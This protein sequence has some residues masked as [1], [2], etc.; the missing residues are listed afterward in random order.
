MKNWI[1]LALVMLLATPT[2]YAQKNKQQSRKPTSVERP[3]QFVLLAFDGSK[4]NDFWKESIDFAETVKTNNQAKN[5]LVR[6][7]YF[8]NP[9]YYLH[10]SEKYNYTTPMLNK[11]VSCIGWEADKTKL[12]LRV[13]LTN[14][15]YLKGHEIASHA[16]AHCDQ[17]G[18]DKGDPMFG[19]TW[20][21]NAW[22][23]EFTQFN[24]LL[25]NVFALNKLPQP[26]QYPPSGFAF[27][28]EN[29]V[30]F[31]AP[32]L[33]YTDGLWPTLQKHGFRY[34]TS[35]S[36]APNYWPQ[37]QNWGGWNFPLARIKIAG[38]NRTTLS[39]DFNWLV[40]HSAGASKPGLTEEERL[41][42]KQQMLDS[43]NFYFK[44]NYFGGRA[45]VHI[46]HHF[47]KWNGSAYWDAMKEFSDLVCNR[48]EVRC[49]TY[50]EYA[51]WL[52]G[53]DQP[54][55][56]AYRAGNFD[57]L[58]DDNSIKNIAAPFL[59][60]VRLDQ[61]DK[62]FEAVVD[63]KDVKMLKLT[64]GSVEL[65]VNFQTQKTT[66]ISKDDLIKQYGKGSTI[67]VRSVLLN[68][69]KKPLDWSTYKVEGLGTVSEK[70]SDPI[71]N[72]ANEPETSH[73]HADD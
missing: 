1:N 4:S 61:S 39:M 24:T 6:F 44:E 67:F 50:T 43:Y 28:P 72:L 49:V 53:L 34:D 62:T 7:T 40:Y 21:A 69:D 46:G 27:K 13:N 71:E 58:K 9:V 47:S 56:E 23:S 25:F 12:P 22:D 15:A 32:L 73:A 70:I 57:K 63:P 20:D 2:V 31:R 8:V 17:T 10:Q 48:P 51:D 3:P 54:T 29:I 36:S 66:A 38:T 26:K 45:P 68:K 35:K 41:R 30:G 55:Y 52:D 60:R 14:T 5:N 33:A 42:F 37:K 19:N 18:R 16:N 59:A 11:S 64:K 65:Q